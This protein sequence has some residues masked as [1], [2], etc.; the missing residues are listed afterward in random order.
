MK[1]PENSLFGV[2]MR[3]RWWTSA[4]AAVGVFGLAR[5]LLPGDLAFF[6]ALPFGV[7]ACVVAWHEIRRPRGARLERRLEALRAMPWEE[8]AEALQAGYRREGYTVKRIGGAA[9]FELE[10]A[11][12]VSL[13]SARRWKA[14]VTGIEPLRELVA[15]GEKRGASE[16][17][18][19]VAGGMS[20]RARAFLAEKGIRPVEGGELV[21]LA[22]KPR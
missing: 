20:E 11:G 6:A 2:L 14:A 4:L 10:K 3:A 1:L 15:A 9:D 8:F 12:R 22:R 21:N 16:C 19:A 17:L 5:L 18:V 7:I 13:L